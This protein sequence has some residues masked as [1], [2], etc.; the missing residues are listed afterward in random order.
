MVDPKFIIGTKD[1]IC[2]IDSRDIPVANK[3]AE[4]PD[5][6]VSLECLNAVLHIMDE[7]GLTMP[8]TISEALNLYVVLTTLIEAEVNHMM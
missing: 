6:P 7:Q 2:P 8:D 5:P 4:Q 3:Y 1:Y